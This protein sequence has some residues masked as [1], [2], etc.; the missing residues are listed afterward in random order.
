MKR[1]TGY[2]EKQRNATSNIST[3][4][5]WYVIVRLSINLE[6]EGALETLPDNN[7]NTTCQ[8]VISA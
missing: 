2:I 5:T 1:Y 3:K 4:Y 8:P 6:K 7:I